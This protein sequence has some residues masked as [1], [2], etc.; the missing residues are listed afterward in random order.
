[1]KVIGL[2]NKEYKWNYVKYK[3]KAKCSKLHLRARK[4]LS[5]EFPYDTI[6]EELTLPGTKNERQA[7]PLFADFFVPQRKLMVE[8]Q[9]QQHYKFNSHFF[10]NKIEF[11]KAQA[12]DRNKQEWCEVNDL[13]L[14][15]LPYNETDEK[16]LDRIRNR[17]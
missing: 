5:G 11:F 2:D 10:D 9:G 3:P 15:Q 1:M 13:I 14:I 12:R 6:C 4:L 16:W 17:L 7:R 8:V